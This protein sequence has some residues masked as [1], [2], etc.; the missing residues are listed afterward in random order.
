M[1]PRSKRQSFLGANSDHSLQHFT[2][3]VVGGSGGGSPICQQ[4]AHIG[5]GKVHLFDPAIAKAHH[6]HRLIG[7]STTAVRRGWSKVDVARR[8]FKRVNPDGELVPH[9]YRWQDAHEILRACDVVFTCVDGYLARAELEAYL[10]RF[11]VPMIDIGMDVA[12]SAAGGF[13]IRGQMILSLPGA[14]CMRCFGFLRDSAMAEEAARYGAA[15]DNAQVV[16]PNAA[17]ASAAVGMG[18]S[19]LLPWQSG[20][21]VDPYLVYDGN[22]MVFT[23]WPGLRHLAGLTCTHFPADIEVGDPMFSLISELLKSA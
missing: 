17:L 23:P 8:L 7:V 13:Q 1:K 4:L 15:G 6:T 9:P 14:H 22:R 18:M 5:F 16:W 12:E 3:G 21:R 10:R 11:H 19:L 2:A 20:L